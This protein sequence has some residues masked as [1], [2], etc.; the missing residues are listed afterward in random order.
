MAEPDLTQL[1]GSLTQI[2]T[3]TRMANQQMGQLIQT[4][5]TIL[6]FGGAFGTFTLSAAATTTV[7]NSSVAANSVIIWVP[8]NAAA[9]AFNTAATALYLSARTAG[10]S[11][12]LTT[13]NGGSAAGSEQLAY[14]IINPSG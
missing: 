13:A 9:A 10:T 14:V 12:A 2:A 5:S 3:N 6:P 1:G 8:T 7:T 4:L 11:F